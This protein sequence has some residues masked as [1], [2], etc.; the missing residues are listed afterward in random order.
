MPYADPAKQRAAQAKAREKWRIK[1]EKRYK[2]QQAVK[3]AL[4][5]GKL[6]R[7]PGCAACKRKR[8][9]EAHHYDYDR[10]LDVTWLCIKCHKAAHA[11]VGFRNTLETEC[12]AELAHTS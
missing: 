1:A 8:N 4:K 10:P 9:L 12:S 3:N 6:I 11:I 5:S 7:W 2:A